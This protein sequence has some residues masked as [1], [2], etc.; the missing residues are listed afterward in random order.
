MGTYR[1]TAGAPDRAKALAGVLLVHAAIGAVILSGLDVQTMVRTVERLKTFDINLPPPPPPP[2]PPP[3]ETKARARDDEGAA[4]KKAL[5]TPVV[6]P[7][8]KIV[9]PAEP[10][11]VAAPVAA[12]GSAPTAGASTAGTGTGAGGSGTG[13]GGGGDGG[14][15]SASARWVSGGLYD[16]DNRGGLFQGIVGVRFR[17]LATGQVDGCRVTRASGNRELDALTCRL[18]EQRLRFSPARDMAGRPVASEVGT[19]YTW[20]VRRRRF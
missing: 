20:G 18:L 16:S 4:G 9:I 14:G 2:P 7:L 8:P 15:L 13:P 11:I 19:T 5:P 1:G 6:A 3:Q 12:S 10:P 17:V